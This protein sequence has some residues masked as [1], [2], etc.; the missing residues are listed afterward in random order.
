MVAAIKSDFKLLN[1]TLSFYFQFHLVFL[2]LSMTNVYYIYS[3]QLA[4]RFQQNIYG[5][6]DTNAVKLL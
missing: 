3:E 2:V 6:S 5:V 4:S 1:N